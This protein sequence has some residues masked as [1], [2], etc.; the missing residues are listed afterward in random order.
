MAVFHPSTPSTVLHR[1]VR[2]LG[3]HIQT[4]LAAPSDKSTDLVQRHLDGI[5]STVTLSKRSGGGVMSE[6]CGQA[7]VQ[8]AAGDMRRRLVLQGPRAEEAN[9]KIHSESRR[10]FLQRR[11]FHAGKGKDLTG[12]ADHPDV[13]VT[14]PG[15]PIER[16]EGISC[17]IA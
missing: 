2:K 1:D 5:I 8:T 13:L 12:E 14:L 16:F 17:D 15:T 10:S 7:C 4:D 9:H 3:G 11:R 6:A